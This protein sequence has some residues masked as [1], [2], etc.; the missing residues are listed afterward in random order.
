MNK[1]TALSFRTELF[2]QFIELKVAYHLP[3]VILPATSMEPKTTMAAIAV[4]QIGENTQSHGQEITFVSFKMINSMTKVLT[5]PIP[6][7][8]F[9]LLSSIWTGTS[10]FFF[11]F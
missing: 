2:Y 1:E 7:L 11:I 9:F 3:F 8:L 10:K 6:L 5:K 4:I